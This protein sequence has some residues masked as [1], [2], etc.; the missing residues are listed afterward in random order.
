MEH[1]LPYPALVV[2][3]ISAVRNKNSTH[4]PTSGVMKIK[5]SRCDLFVDR[6]R[7]GHNHTLTVPEPIAFKKGTRVELDPGT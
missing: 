3:E 6:N 1:N 5:T 4:H 2:K 7:S